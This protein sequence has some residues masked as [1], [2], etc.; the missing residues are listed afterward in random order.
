MPVPTRAGTRYQSIFHLGHEPHDF[1][2][3]MKI[4]DSK[5]NTIAKNAPV[6]LLAAATINANAVITRPRRRSVKLKAS[7][8]KQRVIALRVV[9]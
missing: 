3:D 7:W 2:A 8:K 4:N 5:P 1:S 9:K 6:S